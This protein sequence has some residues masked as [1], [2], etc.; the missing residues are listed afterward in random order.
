MYTLAMLLDWFTV[1][2]LAYWAVVI[3]VF[4]WAIWGTLRMRNQLLVLRGY[5]PLLLDVCCSFD[6]VATVGAKNQ[7]VDL[8]VG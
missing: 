5:L 7:P 1:F 3:G 2:A 8:A 4:T 6:F